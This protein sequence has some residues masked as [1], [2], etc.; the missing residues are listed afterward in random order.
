MKDFDC[1]KNTLTITATDITYFRIFSNK[2]L[3][4]TT[5]QQ[6]D[7]GNNLTLKIHFIKIWF[8]YG[9]LLVPLLYV[10]KLGNVISYNIILQEAI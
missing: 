10:P 7:N 2:I 6:R 4:K 1:N 5:K 9:G 3:T 8:Y